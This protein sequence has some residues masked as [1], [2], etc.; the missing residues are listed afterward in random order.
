MSEATFVAILLKISVKCQD[1]SVMTESSFNV[2]S[3]LFNL[4]SYVVDGQKVKH[5]LMTIGGYTY[6]LH[7]H[8]K[9]YIPIEN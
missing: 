2:I 8:C 1:L 5:L 6:I 9:V 7:I 4:L 3:V